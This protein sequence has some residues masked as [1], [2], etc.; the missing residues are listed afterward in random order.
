[1]YAQKQERGAAQVKAGVAEIGAEQG[2]AEGEGHGVAWLLGSPEPRATKS[3]DEER[4]GGPA[5]A[6]WR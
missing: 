4:T 5:I 6:F 1:M 2:L 3:P